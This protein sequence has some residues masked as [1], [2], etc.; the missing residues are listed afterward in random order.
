MTI[1]VTNVLASLFDFVVRVEDLK[2]AIRSTMRTKVVEKRSNT[3]K[4]E[5]RLRTAISDCDDFH[6]T[7]IHIYVTYVFFSNLFDSVMFG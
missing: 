3:M 6:K 5:L 4:S 2:F 1:T 7:L